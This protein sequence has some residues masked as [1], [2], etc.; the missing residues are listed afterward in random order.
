MTTGS[1]DR[2]SH[3]I[4]S[5]TL[6]GIDFIEIASADQKNLRVHFLNP[7]ALQ[8]TVSAVAIS[9]GETIPTVAVNPIQDSDWSTEEGHPLLNLRV[10]APGDFSLYTLSLTSPK[11]DPFF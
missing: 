5:T 11:L 10:V 3:L 4:N 2:R 9:G 1:K 8:G 7:V 6:N